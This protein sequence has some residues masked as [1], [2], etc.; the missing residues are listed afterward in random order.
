MANT[1]KVL[2]SKKIL[3]NNIPYI[4]INSTLEYKNYILSVVIR[5]MFV[6]S[7]NLSAC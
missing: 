1:I 7:H 4:K 6:I 5:I 2:T 3:L